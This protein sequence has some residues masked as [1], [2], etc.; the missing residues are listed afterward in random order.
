[1]QK[2]DEQ[3]QAYVTMLKKELVPAMGCTEPIAIAY[4]AALARRILEEP[5][6]EVDIYASGNIIKN[7][8]SVTVPNTRG[9]KGIEAAAAIGIIAGNSDLDLEVIKE[10]IPEQIEEMEIFLNSGKVH[11]HKAETRCALE[12]GIEAVSKHHRVV[13]CIQNEHSNVVH[14]EKDGVVLLDKKRDDTRNESWEQVSFSMEGIYEFACMAD[15]DDVKEVLD[16]QIAYNQAIAEEG[17]RHSYGANIGSVLLS[18]Y[19]DRVEIRARAMAAAGSDARMGGC[20]LPVVINSG[21]GNQGMCASLPVLEYAKELGS[22]QETL[23]RALI[24]SNLSTLYQKKHIGRLSAYCGAVS[25]GAG[26]G[27]G[28]AYL[29]DQNYDHICHAIV[30]ALAI[31]SGMICDGAKPS[32]AAKISSAVD[33]GIIG[34]MMYQKGTQFCRGEGI[35]SMN[36]ESTIDNV[37]QLAREG[38]RETDDEII[39]MMMKDC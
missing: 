9:K 1:M 2:K 20:E 31:T 24:I 19:G 3:Y 5:V 33:A 17:L 27:A 29:L 15:I 37:G 8:K 26:A 25:A 12:I 35:V 38:M 21:S 22:D 6:E 13:L 34:C 7:V 10:V 28:I 23:Y 18:T 39:R 32:C 16:R 4:G 36:I 11:I 14:I 30:N